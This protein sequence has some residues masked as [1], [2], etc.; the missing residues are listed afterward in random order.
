M[1][2]QHVCFPL[3]SWYFCKCLAV[4]TPSLKRSTLPKHYVLRETSSQ[5]LSLAHR[6][7]KKK[8]R[9]CV[10]T[11]ERAVSPANWAARLSVLWVLRGYQPFSD[12]SDLLSRHPG[13][14]GV[15]TAQSRDNTSDWQPRLP[16]LHCS[17]PYV[18]Q[19]AQYQERAF[20]C[21]SVSVSIFAGD[22]KGEEDSI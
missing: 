15:L 19:R 12:M 16:P 7:K 22:Q 18:P 5:T 14:I 17:S 2:S 6:K 4:T 9:R 3:Q 13:V 10:P 20:H 1:I 11:S 21:G 8:M